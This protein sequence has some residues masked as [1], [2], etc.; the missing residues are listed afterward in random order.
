MSGHRG[1]VM[2]RWAWQMIAWRLA[3][4]SIWITGAF[5]IILKMGVLWLIVMRCWI[6]GGI[7][8]RHWNSAG[9]WR[10]S[11][12]PAGA[13][14]CGWD[15]CSYDCLRSYCRKEEGKGT[16]N[17]GLHFWFFLFLHIDIYR[18]A[19]YNETKKKENFFTLYYRKP[20]YNESKYKKGA[21]TM[22]HT[23]TVCQCYIGIACN[24]EC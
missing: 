4:R 23:G 18:D 11:I 6:S 19:I 14:L 9:K 16:G 1:S 13:R 20:I 8:S 24:E 17:A 3:A 7:W 2:R 10:R 22:T 12:R 15:S 5:I 21:I